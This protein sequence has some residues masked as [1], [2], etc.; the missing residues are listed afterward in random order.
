MRATPG[1]RILIR[2]TKS[3]H[4]GAGETQDIEATLKTT[5][6]ALEWTWQAGDLDFKRAMA[7]LS[8]GLSMAEVGEELGVSKS[9]VHRWKQKAAGQGSF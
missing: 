2:Y 1:T 3:R 9:T 6:G 4:M 8:D 7:L 5:D